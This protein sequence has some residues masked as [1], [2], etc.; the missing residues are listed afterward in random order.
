MKSKSYINARAQRGFTLIELLA[1]VAIIGLLA[2]LIVPSVSDARK[3]SQITVTVA[4]LAN[5][6]KVTQALDE[7]P[8]LPLT[9]AMQDSDRAANVGG[10]TFVGTASANLNAS[11]RFD[12][13]LLS[14]GKI[15]NLFTS[16]LVNQQLP[17]TVG[18]ETTPIAAPTADPRWNNTSKRFVTVGDVVTTHSWAACARL[19]SAIV[20]GVVADTANGRNYQLDGV[21]PLPT[22]VRVQYAVLPNVTTETAFL[23]GKEINGDGLMQSTVAGSAQTRGK[24]IW[25]AP[26]NGL[27]T[28]FVYL[29]HL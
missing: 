18:T 12:Q 21:T 15:D 11:L 24:A 20:T 5:L 27:T 23:I 3:Q 19:E 25:A 4:D 26:T 7:V 6:A 29:N 28:V 8:V 1:V 13:L 22:T 17:G 14:L 10:T 2:A 16:K 9:E